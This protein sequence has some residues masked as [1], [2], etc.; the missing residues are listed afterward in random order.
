MTGQD[1]I[2]EMSDLQLEAMSGGESLRAESIHIN[3]TMPPKMRAKGVSR[4]REALNNSA[5]LPLANNF[6]FLLI[7]RSCHSKCNLGVNFEYGR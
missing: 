6:V 1:T 3:G 5:R 2:E 4:L 7:V